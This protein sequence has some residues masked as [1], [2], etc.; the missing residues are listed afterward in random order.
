MKV[1]PNDLERLSKAIAEFDTPEVRAKY[2]RGDFPRANK[3]KDLHK[4]F[5]WDLFWAAFDRGF[6]FTDS[7]ALHDA[8]IDTALRKVVPPFFHS[9]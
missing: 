7:P 1:S 2:L 8:H 6:A 9:N 3:T 4:R 5:R